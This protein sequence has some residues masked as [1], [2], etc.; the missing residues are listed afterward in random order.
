MAFPV[1]PIVGA[2]HT[3]G[4]SI[5]TFGNNGWM[6]NPVVAI[7]RG[8]AY[9]SNPEEGDLFLLYTSHASGG[10]SGPVLMQRRGTSWVSVGNHLALL[11]HF[12]ANPTTALDVIDKSCHSFDTLI[13]SA[14]INLNSAGNMFV[15]FVDERN[16]Y[17][18][19]SHADRTKGF[20]YTPTSGAVQSSDWAGDWFRIAQDG[21]LGSGTKLA[22]DMVVSNNRNQPVV[23]S[24]ITGANSVNQPVRNLRYLQLKEGKRVSSVRLQCG[25]GMVI[26]GSSYGVQL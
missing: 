23:M 6:R 22:W 16:F 2:K 9:P 12:T 26:V 13:V 25:S 15:Q 18:N 8:Q 21:H 10:Q 5:W 11:K 19:S 17:I 7:G 24:R 20:G 14:T 4:N 1:S 3:V